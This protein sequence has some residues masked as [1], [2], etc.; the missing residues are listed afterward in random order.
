MQTPDEDRPLSPLHTMT[1]YK[2][3]A[4]HGIAEDLTVLLLTIGT[5]YGAVEYRMDA[6]EAERLALSIQ[7]TLDSAER[8]VQA[9]KN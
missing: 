4:V 8:Q 3:V 9:M 6:D 1:D 7:A 2:M 5:K